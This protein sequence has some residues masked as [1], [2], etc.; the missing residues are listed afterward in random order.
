VNKKEA[1]TPNVPNL[2]AIA[3]FF[4]VALSWLTGE[5]DSRN[6]LPPSHWLVDLDYVEALEAG[7]E[8]VIADPTKVAAVPIPERAKMMP[9]ADYQRLHQKVMA[10]VQRHMRERRGS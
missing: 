4:G 10:I 8:S 6:G 5:C 2:V 7:D 1:A 9:S 3:R